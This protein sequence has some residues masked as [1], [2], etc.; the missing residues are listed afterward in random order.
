MFSIACTWSCTS[1]FK[2]AHV[3]LLELEILSLLS[4]LAESNAG[5]GDEI[6]VMASSSLVES[7]DLCYEEI[8]CDDGQSKFKCNLC[9]RLLSRLQRIEGHLNNKHSKSKLAKIT[10]F[11][12]TVWSSFMIVV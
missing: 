5:S 11:I 12:Q 9:G 1:H 8:I 4:P 3:I 2:C 10:V 6:V 7:S